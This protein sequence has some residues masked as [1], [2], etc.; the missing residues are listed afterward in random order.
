MYVFTLKAQILAYVCFYICF[1]I[2]VNTIS[3]AAVQAR[4][5]SGKE[6]LVPEN[7]IRIW[8][9]VDDDGDNDMNEVSVDDYIALDDDRLA[10]SNG[11]KYTSHSDSEF[12]CWHFVYAYFDM[13]VIWN[14][15]QV[16]CIYTE[17]KK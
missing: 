7:Y 16:S 1:K 3:C 9:P 17:S 14:C 13:C 12:T 5:G 2:C 8:N 11:F 4:D 10:A 6:G 15:Q